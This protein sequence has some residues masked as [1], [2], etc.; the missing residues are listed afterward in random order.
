MRRRSSRIRI[1]LQ[2]FQVSS[3]F[4]RRLIPQLTIFLERLV[5]DAVQLRR[6]LRVEIYRGR[7]R[8]IQDRI[9]NYAVA[10][11]AKR[12]ISRGHFVQHD[13]K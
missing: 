8:T 1:S 9:K 13:S 3:H 2:P 5:N 11:S 12:Q 6:D 10:L 4:R 7:R